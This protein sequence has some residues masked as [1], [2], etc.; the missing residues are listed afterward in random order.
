M[1]PNGRARASVE[2]SHTRTPKCSRD[3]KIRC[4]GSSAARALEPCTQ[5]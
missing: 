3:A 4:M 1:E 2:C 5:R